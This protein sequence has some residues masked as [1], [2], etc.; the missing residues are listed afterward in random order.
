LEGAL[1]RLIARASLDGTDPSEIDLGYTKEVLKDLISDHKRS[2]TPEMIIRAVSN[3]Y[4]LK[5]GQLKSKNNS[6]A[7]ARPRQIAMYVTKQLTSLSLPQIGKDFGGKHHTTVLH[8]IRK[9]DSL[10]KKDPDILTAIN[11]IT[12]S[13][14]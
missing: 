7:I 5:P 13:F 14:N 12:S 4:G 6:R 11:K 9:I 3:Y 8:S 1:I 10:R 2:L